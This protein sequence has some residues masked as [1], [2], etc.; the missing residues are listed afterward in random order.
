MDDI[1]CLLV[2]FGEAG[3]PVRD[4]ELLLDCQNE[5]RLTLSQKD[6]ALHWKRCVSLVVHPHPC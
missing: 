5:G 3:E 4:Q 2:E 1:D 6:L